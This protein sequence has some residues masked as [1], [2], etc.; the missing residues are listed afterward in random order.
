MVW[1]FWIEHLGVVLSGDSLAC[2]TATL[3]LKHTLCQVLPTSKFNGIVVYIHCHAL[4]IYLFF[5]SDTL[6]FANT[7][8]LGN[9]SSRCCQVSIGDQMRSHSQSDHVN[10][11]LL[12]LALSA[13]MEATSSA[14]SHHSQEKELIYSVNKYFLE[15]KAIRG[16]LLDPS[17]AVAQIARATNAKLKNKNITS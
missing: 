16:P 2:S 4:F 3:I 14:H 5:F 10:P 6:F 9:V 8:I 15:E 12:P 17:R 7:T 1:P 11:W 13:R